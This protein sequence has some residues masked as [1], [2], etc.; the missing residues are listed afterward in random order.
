MIVAGHVSVLLRNGASIGATPIGGHENRWLPSVAQLGAVQR[1]W[2][3]KK[4]WLT[5][6]D[7]VG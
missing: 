6:L 4:G 7:Q 3:P 5:I 1:R 2:P